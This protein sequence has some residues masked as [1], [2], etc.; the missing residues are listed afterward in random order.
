MDTE[1]RDNV[2]EEMYTK[3]I[4]KEIYL[5]APEDILDIED[6]SNQI[7]FLA[8]LVLAILVMGVVALIVAF[9]LRRKNR[10]MA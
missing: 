7:A 5:S 3:T 4:T 2:I 9:I 10:K 8:G 6:E 1:A